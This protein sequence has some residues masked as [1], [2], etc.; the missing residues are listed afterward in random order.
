MPPA[1]SGKCA[2]T[3]EV[4]RGKSSQTRLVCNEWADTRAAGR[5]MQRL[6]APSNHLHRGAPLPH[7]R[8]W[9]VTNVCGYAA[10]RA[11]RVRRNWPDI[12]LEEL[13]LFYRF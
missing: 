7:R 11:Y 1:P 5:A 6:P 3:K 13:P 9:R 12:S 10:V 8:R 2:L 4:K